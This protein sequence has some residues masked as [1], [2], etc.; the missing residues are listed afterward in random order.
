MALQVALT[1]MILKLSLTNSHKINANI[2]FSKGQLHFLSIYMEKLEGK[3]EKLKNPYETG[4]LQ[5]ASWAMGRL[6]GWSGYQSQGPPGYISIKDG[7]DRF[8]DKAD[9]FQMALEYLKG[10]DVYR[11]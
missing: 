9:G 4:S 10:K 5:W 3:T 2:I 7:T 6:G 1:T 11:G 8:Y